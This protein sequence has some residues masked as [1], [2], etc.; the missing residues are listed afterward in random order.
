MKGERLV[1][2]GYAHV[3]AKEDSL[4]FS[5]GES[6]PVHEFHYWDS[7]QNGENF[8]VE[9]PVSGRSWQGGFGTKSLYAGFPHLYFWGEPWLGERFVEAAAGYFGENE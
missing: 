4:L 6:V 3:T 8:Q 9:K 1:R 5:K 7:T 2:F